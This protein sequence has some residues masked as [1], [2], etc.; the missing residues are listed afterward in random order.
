MKKTISKMLICSILT[1]STVQTYAQAKSQ[2]RVSLTNL[3]LDYDKEMANP[4]ANLDELGRKLKAD[5]KNSLF[6]LPEDQV[7]AEII[8]LL[9][10]IPMSHK[11][12]EL[13]KQVRFSTLDDLQKLLSEDTTILDTLS[14]EGSNYNYYYRDNDDSG[15]AIIGIVA[16]V[17]FIAAFTSNKSKESKEDGPSVEIREYYSY[18][19][20]IP[21][22]DP[23]NK[24][25]C[26][27]PQVIL[28]PSEYQQIKEDAR[29]ACESEADTCHFGDFIISKYPS[30]CRYEAMYEGSIILD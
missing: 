23:E 28:S 5:I 29:M 15:L 4:K 17:A 13:I 2:G 3:Y 27:A 19:R 24:Y 12:E 25:D 20:F 16:F 6:S 10:Q 18:T 11:R 21:F 8:E 9:K 22:S 26:P 30:E 1:I 7:K 14:G